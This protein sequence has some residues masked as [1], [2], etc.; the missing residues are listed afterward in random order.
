M[1]RK[2]G[3]CA[4]AQQPET[5]VCQQC[6]KSGT[7]IWDDVSRLNNDVVTELVGIDGPFFER[8][9]RNPPYPI[10]MVCRACGGVAAI[11]FPSTSLHGR[12]RYN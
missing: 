7:I 11:A 9:S 3:T 5:V 12:E 6:G 2:S 1:D 10:E 4:I 8:L